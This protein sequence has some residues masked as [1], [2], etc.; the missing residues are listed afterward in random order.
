MSDVPDEPDAQTF[1]A[2]LLGSEMLAKC[3]E[4]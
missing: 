2:P 3:K 1:E 4:V